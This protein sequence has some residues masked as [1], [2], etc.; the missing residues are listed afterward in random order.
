MP[1]SAFCR[2]AFR[3]DHRAA[4]PHRI[5]PEGPPTS[6]R[7][8]PGAFCRSAFR[9]D[10]R[11]ARPHR[12][13]P[14]GPPTRARDAP[15]AFC[16][17]AFRRDHRAA[18]RHR[19]GPEGPPT[20][21]TRCPRAHSVGAPSGAITARHARTA[22]GLKALLHLHL[23]AMPHSAFCRSAFRRDHRAARRH[24]IGQKALLQGAPQGSQDR[25]QQAGPAPWSSGLRVDRRSIGHQPQRRHRRG[26]PQ[27][28]VLDA[29]PRFEQVAVV[30]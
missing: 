5:G 16:R 29:P 28:Q 7:D 2:S 18:R 22:S 30:A 10:H 26:A 23:H 24:H 21:C 3:R 6:A 13:G 8:A 9:R 4:R 17:S 11:A 12:I 14:E 20:S 19:I 1:H 25:G 15:G 27:R